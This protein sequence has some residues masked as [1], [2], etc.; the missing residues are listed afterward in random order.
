V[1][2]ERGGG[3]MQGSIQQGSS[4]GAAV[5]RAAPSAFYCIAVCCAYAATSV[6]ITFANKIVLS[7]YD[8]KY[9]MS[10]FLAQ[11]LIGTAAMTLLF[12]A[13]VC[14][15]PPL[16]YGTLRKSVPLAFW[17]FLYV[18][19]GLGS[20]RSLTVPTWSALRRLTAVFILAFD[21]RYD[22]KVA[23]V[24]IWLAVLFMLMGAVVAA[25]GD[26]DGTL[27]GYVQVFLNCLSSAIYLRAIN[28]LRK[29][30]GVS[31]VG[32][33]YL[34]NLLCLAPVLTTIWLSDEGNRVL[35]FPHAAEAGFQIAL[36]GSA[37]LAGLLNYLVFLSAA[38]N[39][40]L[41]TS[42][43][44]QAKN[45]VS[46][47]GGYLL[48]PS[49]AGGGIGPDR[50]VNAAGCSIGLCASMWYGFLKYRERYPRTANPAA[51]V[52]PAASS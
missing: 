16:D 3:K 11:L 18:I 50:L 23:P 42:I 31:E 43:T 45:V 32:A 13:G 39:S 15:C 34:T 8:F 14:D 41:T 28:Q 10:L 36:F 2:R 24:R 44:G 30:A 37:A 33:L 26:L 12:A 5:T 51:A 21:W 9:E 52:A 35:L 25:A 29:N 7:A 38:V 17:F 6:A 22:G 27:R 49:S 46:A 40:P 1:L 4:G 20:L 19:T 48:L 47:L